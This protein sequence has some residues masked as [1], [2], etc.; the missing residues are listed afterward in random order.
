MWNYHDDY[1]YR[2][3]RRRP[4]YYYE[5]Y[6]RPSYYQQQLFNSNYSTISQNMYNLGYMQGVNQS[7]ISNQMIR[8]LY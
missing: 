7:I 1:Y 5:P 4:E 6:F 2:R 8:N 3:R